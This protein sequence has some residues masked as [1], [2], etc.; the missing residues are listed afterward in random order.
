MKLLDPDHR[1][2]SRRR[3]WTQAAWLQVI[4]HP[5]LG[6]RSMENNREIQDSVLA[7]EKITKR[8]LPQKCHILESLSQRL[9]DQCS[10]LKKKRGQESWNI[11]NWLELNL[12]DMWATD[13]QCTA[14]L[15]SWLRKWNE[16]RNRT[17]NWGPENKKPARGKIW[18]RKTERW[19][20]LLFLWQWQHLLSTY[21]TIKGRFTFVNFIESSQ[22]PARWVLLASF[23]QKRKLNAQRD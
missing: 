3:I 2:S 17:G 14:E 8:T 11:Q 12:K 22:T 18:E 7:S 16:R 13:R 15:S 6:L 5:V 9:S 1:A 10:R 20:T 4:L 23:F 19:N 21:S